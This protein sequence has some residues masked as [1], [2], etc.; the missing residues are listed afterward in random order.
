M[1]RYIQLNLYLWNKQVGKYFRA[2]ALLNRAQLPSKRCLTTKRIR[3]DLEKSISL[4]IEPLNKSILRLPV[5]YWQ[6]NKIAISLKQQFPGYE[7]G[8]HDAFALQFKQLIF[9]CARLLFS[10]FEK[11]DLESIFYSL[12][13][14]QK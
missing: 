5:W 10:C 12:T 14:F 7:I 1:V 6:S 3:R 11:W 13:Y 4:L 8:M 9:E 2:R